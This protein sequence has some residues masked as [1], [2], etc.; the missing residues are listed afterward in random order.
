M[1]DDERQRQ[2]DRAPVPATG[3]VRR[4]AV[5]GAGTMGAQIAALLANQ[6]IPCDLLDLASDAADQPRN[7]L[8]E[9]GKERLLKLTPSPIYGRDVMD[10]IHPGNFSDDLPRLR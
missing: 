5:L 7:R 4:A 9:E 8:A 1:P 10:L 3:I 2:A 6:G